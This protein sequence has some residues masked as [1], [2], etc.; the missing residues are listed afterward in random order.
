MKILAICFQ[1]GDAMPT[2]ASNLLGQLMPEH[3]VDLLCDCEPKQPIKG[4]G[5]CYTRPYPT[6][7]TAWQRRF[8]RWFGA[9]PV[10]NWWSRRVSKVVAKDYDV[11]IS[12]LNNVNLTSIVAG[13]RIAKQLGCKFA[14]YTVDAFPAPGGWIRKKSEFRGKKWI[15][16]RIFSA[17]DLVAASNS[18]MLA[19][20]LSLCKPSVTRK[21]VT[22]LTPSPIGRYEYP[23]SEE[24]LLLY[25]GNFYGLR[26]PSHFLK[27]FKRLLKVYPEAKFMVV[28]RD[29]KLRSVESILTEEERQHIEVGEYTTD[30]APYFRRAKIL[31]DIDA[32][33]VKDP[34]LSSKITSY[35]KI[36]RVILSETGRITPSREMFAGLDTVVQCDHNEE[37]I[38]EGMLR[39]IEIA[40]SAPDY[41]ERDELIEEFSVKRVGQILKTQLE[42]VV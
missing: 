42:E 1:L 16:Q 9:T 12:F 33:R 6:K 22:L 38:Y 25:T 37:S 24:L 8:I 17:A 28:G 7:W 27:A 32:D 29:T 39:A 31:V 11:V 5:R 2:I 35:L 13:K 41:S 20:Q 26:N 34:F 14:I 18:H 3:E 10:S 36:N 30:L 40:D 15:S 19:Y 23:V 21:G 4:I